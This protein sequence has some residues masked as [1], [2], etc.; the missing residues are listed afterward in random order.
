MAVGMLQAF[1]VV[2]VA[3]LIAK[4]Q[5]NPGD[6]QSS[7][8]Q[9]RHCRGCPQ[10]PQGQQIE[11]DREA[12]AQGTD[13]QQGSDRRRCAR[14]FLGRPDAPPDACSDAAPRPASWP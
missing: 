4:E 3:V 6:L 2:P 7:R 11:P 10:G 8:D 9:Q 5:H 1:V 12:I 13:Q 14:A